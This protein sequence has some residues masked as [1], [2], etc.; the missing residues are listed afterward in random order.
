MDSGITYNFYEHCKSNF[1]KAYVSRLNC[2]VS[3]G[4]NIHGSLLG[5]RIKIKIID[6]M[7]HWTLYGPLLVKSASAC[8][9][10]IK[11]IA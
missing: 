10:Q 3:G 7:T 2:K 8:A 9:N 11:N 5:S 1:L 4:W 6:I